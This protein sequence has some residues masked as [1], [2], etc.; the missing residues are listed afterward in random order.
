MRITEGTGAN[1]VPIYLD[2]LWGSIFSFDRQKFF[3][4]WP[5][6]WPYPV[7]VHY[8]KPLGA[9]NDIHQVRAEVMRL[10]SWAMC[11]RMREPNSIAWEAIIGCKRRMW[12]SKFVDSTGANLTGGKALVSTLALRRAL[13]R[14]FDTDENNV[15]VLLPPTVPAVISNMALTFDQRVVTNLNYTCSS[16]ILNECLVQANIKTVITSRKFL[17]KVEL[18]LNAKLILLEELKGEISGVDKAIALVQT[19]LLPASLLGLLA[20]LAPH[21]RQRFADDYFHVGFNG[22][23]E[24]RDAHAWQRASPMSKRLTKRFIWKNG[25][26]Y[27]ASYPFFTH[28]ARP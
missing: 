1:V 7:G 19:Y 21:A 23:A 9:I 15:A 17:E 10:G 12:N 20:G 26:F 16:E 14:H 3:W 4:K 18:K 28:S 8:G 22:Q 2:Q 24:R 6:Q 13:R 11:E 27:S 25:T 5:R